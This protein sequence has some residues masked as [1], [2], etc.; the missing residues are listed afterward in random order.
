MSAIVGSMIVLVVAGCTGSPQDTGSPQ[1]ERKAYAPHIDPADFSTTIDNEYFPLKPGT[2]FFY[3]GGAQQRG[4][5]TVTSETKKIMG[6]ECVVVDHKEWEADKLIERTY[7]WFAQDNEGTVWYFGED[8]K[9]YENGKVVS[10]KGS[11][12]A[13]VDGAKPGIIMPADPRW[14]KPTARST[15]RARPWTWPRC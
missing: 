3:E 15:T 11:W 10:T 1:E 14:E 5:M 13:G 9:E 2:T 12:E 7:D 8:T 6:V 4:E